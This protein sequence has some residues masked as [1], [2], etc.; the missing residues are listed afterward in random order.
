[1][2]I[3]RFIIAGIL[4]TAVLLF[5]CSEKEKNISV[6][7]L[8]KICIELKKDIS[9]LPFTTTKSIPSYNPA[10]P[11]SAAE[12]ENPALFSKIEYIVYHK[13]S[14]AIV[15]H[16]TLTDENSDDFGDY[17]YD[18]LELGE[19]T[20]VLFAHSASDITLTGNLLTTTEV[21]DSFYALEE[22]NIERNNDGSPIEMVLKRIVSRVEL[23]GV[24][25]MPADAS[26]FVLEIA[27]QY[28]QAD[29]KTG[30]GVTPRLLRKEYVIA[31]G[32]EPEDNSL[33]MFHTFV[34]KPLQG[35]TSFLSKI[36]L[37]TLNAQ[38]DTLHTIDLHSVPVMRNRITRYTGSLYAP[39]T[40]DN[41]LQL[42]I[43]DYGLWK[44]TI[45]VPF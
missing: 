9:I 36:K 4:M 21:S 6:H 44:D 37:I 10:D 33:Y 7:E 29:L 24:K 26:K 31:G 8:H 43:E 34:P 18:E 20:I 30:E 19:Y 40:I 3:L 17:V 27:E 16:Y 28:N 39:N 11:R 25:K 22:V 38:E 5:S 1:M 35:D 13:E 2:S 15:K 12:Q 32:T 14:G 41:T 42:E 45:Q 23:V